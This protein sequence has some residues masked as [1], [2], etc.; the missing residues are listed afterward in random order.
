M[1]TIQVTWLEVSQRSGVA[2]Y[3]DKQ[4]FPDNPDSGSSPLRHLRIQSLIFAVLDICGANRAKW[5]SILVHTGVFQPH[6]RPM[7][8]GIPKPFE[9]Q[10]RPTWEAADVESAVRLA[11]DE[12]LRRERGE[13]STREPSTFIVLFIYER[14]LIC[15]PDVFGC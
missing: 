3:T 6:R 10:K 14:R 11:I 5:N 4:T 7:M 12:E 8:N 1:Y 2:V 9:A 13:R 15:I